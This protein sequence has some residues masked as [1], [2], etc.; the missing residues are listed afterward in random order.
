MGLVI[1][2]GDFKSIVTPNFTVLLLVGEKVQTERFLNRGMSIGDRR[3]INQ[4]LKLA[5]AY[6]KEVINLPE[7]YIIISIDY[8]KP[9]EIVEIILAQLKS[10]NN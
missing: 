9:E 8:R 6:E 4:Q 2:L 5:E 7:P 3:M 10:N 1:D